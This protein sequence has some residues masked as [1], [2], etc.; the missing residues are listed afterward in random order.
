MTPFQKKKDLKNRKIDWGREQTFGPEDLLAVLY[1]MLLYLR[2]MVLMIQLLLVFYLLKTFW[3]SFKRKDIWVKLLGM[4][5]DVK[6]PLGP[7][8]R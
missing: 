2:K 1:K 8:L 6:V 5:T 7:L 4:T 3:D